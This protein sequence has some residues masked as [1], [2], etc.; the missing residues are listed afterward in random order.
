MMPS[1]QA[2]WL[3]QQAEAD[4]GGVSCGDASVGRL[5]E[6]ATTGAASVCFPCPPQQLGGLPAWLPRPAA[7][8]SVRGAPLRLGRARRR[9]H[10]AE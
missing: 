4:S 1:C 3:F 2:Q 8:P 10:D 7:E 9:D 6:P 5:G